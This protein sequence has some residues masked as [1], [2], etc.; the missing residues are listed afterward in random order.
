[1]LEFSVSRVSR[2]MVTPGVQSRRSG[3][4][5][6]GSSRWRTVPRMSGTE[7]DK[8]ELVDI[9]VKRKETAVLWNT[10]SIVH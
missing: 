8:R 9:E 4:P 1:M 2:Y 6:P 5:L 7:E 10:L 3:S